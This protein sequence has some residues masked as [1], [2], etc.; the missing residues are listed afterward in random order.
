MNSLMPWKQMHLDRQLPIG[1]KVKYWVY[2][3]PLHGLNLLDL[4]LRRISYIGT[5]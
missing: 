2:F 4:L 3:F 1:A 5:L